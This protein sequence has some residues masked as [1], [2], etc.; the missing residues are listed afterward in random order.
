VRA[1]TPPNDTGLLVEPH[2]EAINRIPCRRPARNLRFGYSARA[3]IFDPLVSFS[4]SG[5][6]LAI[7]V[8][9]FV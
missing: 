2:P 8:P 5:V 4:T 6:P 1:P 7:V 9:V 3:V